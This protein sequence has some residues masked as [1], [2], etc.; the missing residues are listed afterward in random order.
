[1]AVG[2]SVPAA[3]Q[4]DIPADV[5]PAPEPEPVNVAAQDAAGDPLAVLTRWL[6]AIRQR[7][8]HVS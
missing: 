8:A 1:M 4:T 2:Q 5:K 3:G 7:R 6:S